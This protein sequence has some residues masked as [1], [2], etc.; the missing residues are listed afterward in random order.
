MKEHAH[1]AHSF[2]KSIFYEIELTA[3]YCKMLGA[4]VFEKFN[5]DI[6]MEEF[7]VLDTLATNPD[8]CQR[9]LAKII[10]KDRANTGKLLDSLER[11]GFVERTLSV[12]NN[13]P[14]KIAKLTELGHNK[15]LEVTEQIRPH[16]IMVRDKLQTS[17]LG[18]LRDMLRE[19]REVLGGTVD[20]KI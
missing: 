15:T 6:P 16:I 4:Q 12:R 17:D 3:K 7:S 9:D 13:R 19:F 11:K 18:K 8:I 1:I 14:V 5:I 20:T 10:L 2:T